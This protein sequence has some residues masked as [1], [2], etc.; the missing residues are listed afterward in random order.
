MYK[1]QNKLKQAKKK[2]HVHCIENN[3]SYISFSIFKMITSVH[4]KSTVTIKYI[5]I[6]VKHSYNKLYKQIAAYSKVNFIP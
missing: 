4:N 1:S 3:P 6:T 5:N 2:I